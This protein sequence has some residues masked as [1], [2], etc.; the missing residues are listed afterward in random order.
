MTANFYSFSKRRNS[1]KL[2]TGTGTQKTIY[3]KEDTS[4]QSPSIVLDGNDVTYDYCYIQ[5]FG[6]YYFVDDIIILTNG[7]TQ[8]N[9]SEDVL[10]SNKTA[11]GNT[12]AEIAYSSTGYDIWKNDSRI[13]TKNIINEAAS[14]GVAPGIFDL[15]GCFVLT[16]VNDA[17]NSGMT[18][19]YIVNTANMQTLA[20]ELFTS[21]TLQTEL[22]EY[23]Q[24]P[25]DSIID[26]KW[27]P[28][29]YNEAPGSTANIVLGTRSTN[30]QG[31]KLQYPCVK[32]SSA[33]V[34]IPWAY[35]DFRRSAPYTSLA[36]WIP[37][38]SYVE[39]N[40]SEQT[41]NTSLKFEFCCDWGC[42]DICCN[43]IHPVSSII[44][45]S[46]SYNVAVPVPISQITLD[47]GGIISN[48]SNFLGS[49][50]NTGIAAGA[51]SIG[52]AVSGAFSMLMSGAG[53][54]LSANRRVSSTKGGVGGRA[55]INEGIDVVIYSY[56]VET[57]NPDNANYIAVWGRPVGQTHA[58][59][60]HSGYVECIGASIAIS[61]ENSEREEINSYLNSGFYYE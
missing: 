24:S 51:Q 33:T 17:S 23:L 39:I 36:A 32:K 45:Q 16:V 49:A 2:P 1:T 43:I 44:Y 55:V 34:S 14:S 15:S 38:Y 27:L 20:A 50:A 29:D 60:T 13:P 56:S 47:I 40:A 35:S 4:I 41:Q 53:A 30:A 31:I 46:Y 57:E 28:F 58:I 11:V 7:T 48:T 5:E 18:C 54:I 26:C 25:F 9:L 3:L 19:Q 6:R 61:G 22:K 10:A 12:V 42:G 59:N 37:G 8:Y 52:G 21:T